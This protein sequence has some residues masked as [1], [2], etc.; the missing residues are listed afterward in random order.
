MLEARGNRVAAPGF[1]K[2]DPGALHFF[3]LRAKIIHQI[4]VGA[5]CIE[6]AHRTVARV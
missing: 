5:D 3:G 2:R 1:V 4:Q 6:S